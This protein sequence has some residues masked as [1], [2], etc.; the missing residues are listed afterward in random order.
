M[1]GEG[2]EGGSHGGKRGMCHLKLQEEEEGRSF[3]FQLSQNIRT[4]SRS[5]A[6]TMAA[7]SISSTLHGSGARGGQVEVDRHEKVGERV[8]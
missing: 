8:E 6:S 2:G 3:P 1:V 5:P 4:S 7:V